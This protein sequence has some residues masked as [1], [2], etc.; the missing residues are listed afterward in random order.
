MKFR[1]TE[2]NFYKTGAYYE[3]KAAVFTF[4][5]QKEDECSIVLVDMMYGTKQEIS[6]PPEYSFGS[7]RSVTIHGFD[8]TKYAYYYLINGEKHIDTYATKIYGREVWNDAARA[9]NDYDILCGIDGSLFNWKHDILPEITRDKM[10]LYKLHVR[11]F[12]MDTAGVKKH[13]GTFEAVSDRVDYIK[14]MGFTSILLMPVYEFEEMDIPV[15]HDIPEYARPEYARLQC[16]TTK[17][18]DT[19]S[20][21]VNFWGYAPGNY[22]AVK[23]SYASNPCDAANE[24]RRLIQKLHRNNLE[25]ILEMYFPENTDHNMIIDCLRFWVLQFHVDGFRL[26]GSKL[27]VTAIIQDAILSRSKILYQEFDMSAVPENKNYE[28]LYIDKEE[29]QFPARMMLNH[30]NCSMQQ[31]LNQQRKQGDNVGFINY[32]SSNNGFTLTDIFM[33]NDRHNEDN[34]ENN[35][36]GPAWNFSNNYGCEGPS[37]KKFIRDMRSLKWK[38]AMMILFLAQG[39]PMIMAGDEICNSQN[40]NNNAYCQDN[41]VGWVNWSNERSRKANIKFLTDLIRFRDEHPV[42]STAKPFKFC[43]YKAV[44]YPDMSYHGK[45][46]WIGEDETNKLCVGVMYCG[47]YSGSGSDYIY[48]GYNFYSSRE[49]LALPKLKKGKKWYMVADSS[50]KDVFFKEENECTD[51]QYA[52][53]SPQSICILIGK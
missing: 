19:T 34:G 32:I 21:K 5:A 37:R 49:K 2:G 20:S 11:G 48:V 14:K 16:A 42:I 46:A 39:V 52:D 43:D 27:P 4:M 23:A 45:N 25:C 47:E 9:A 50:Q 24:L 22:F 8:P 28:N 26:M 53:I 7:L 12:S 6:I 3:N 51:Q 13:A 40:G 44:G 35:L 1:L 18:D 41:S 10:K 30:I 15:K 29:Y 38:D 33:Y 36:D 31:L 17:Q